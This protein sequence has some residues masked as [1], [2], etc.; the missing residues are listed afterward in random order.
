MAHVDLMF[1]P[2]KPGDNFHMQ[3]NDQRLGQVI[4]N[5]ID[6]ARSFA[7]EG[8]HVTITAKR[9]GDQIVIWVEDCGPGIKEELRERVF[10]R[11]YTDRPENEGFGN[12]SGLGLSICRQ[13]VEAHRAKSRW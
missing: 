8:T 2:V 5:L 13:I 7:P 3:G 12:N 1:D 4:N 11:F 9:S 6:N 10:E